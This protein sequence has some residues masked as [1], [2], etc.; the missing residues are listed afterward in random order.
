MLGDLNINAGQRALCEAYS[1]TASCY[2]FRFDAF[3]DQD[4]TRQRLVTHGAE[5][6]PLFLNFDGLG[7]ETNPFV[8]AGQGYRDLAR[9]MGLFWASFI[10]HADPN[11]GLEGMGR[12]RW[13]AYSAERP[14]N[15]VMNESGVAWTESD[16][17][18]VEAMKL[19]N[20]V[21]HSVLDK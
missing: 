14:V 16:T 10:A 17:Y 5:I 9:L 19:I 3:P 12:T 8:G 15:L 18:R 1:Q 7:L 6:A 13:P 21:Q 20:D 11:V 2:S 4:A